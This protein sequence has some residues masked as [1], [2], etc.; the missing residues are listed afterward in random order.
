MVYQMVYHGRVPPRSAGLAH[1]ARDD[2]GDLHGPAAA[3]VDTFDEAAAEPRDERVVDRGARV[4]LAEEV[5]HE[6]DRA[7]RAD[8][9]RDALSGVLRRRAVDRLEHRDLPPM[10]DPRGRGAAAADER[11]APGGP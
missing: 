11:P 5:E 1:P 10:D 9:A 8:R 6:R 3:G 4:G 2:L 7:D